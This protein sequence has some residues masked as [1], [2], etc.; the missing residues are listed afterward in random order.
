VEFVRQTFLLS[1]SPYFAA[2]RVTDWRVI[3]DNDGNRIAHTRWN[4]G[5]RHLK[6]ESV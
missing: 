5:Q 2:A 1:R 3:L 6:S 4:G